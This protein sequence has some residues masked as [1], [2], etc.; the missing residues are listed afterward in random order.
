[1]T[2]RD[3]EGYSESIYL[4][5]K[6]VPTGGWGHAVTVGS[7]L[8][9]AIWEAIYQY[10][11]ENAKA[12]YAKLGLDLDPIRKEVMLDLLHNMGFG[13]VQE[14]KLMLA[15]LKKKDW[16]EAARQ[17]LD[18]GYKLDVRY[19]RAYRNAAMLESGKQWPS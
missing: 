11:L 6:G 5:T 13:G 12:D 2:T 17:L 1:M 3:N 7:K 4:D 8:P 16:P 14:F 18:S 9:K 15:A 10:D 19:F